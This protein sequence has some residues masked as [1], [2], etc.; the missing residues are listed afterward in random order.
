MGGFARLKRAIDVLRM[1][2]PGPS[3]LVD[4][5]DLVQGSGPA[6]WSRGKVMIAPANALGLDA[7]VP[8]NWEPVY[9]PGRFEELMGALKTRIIAYNFHRKAN[10]ERLFDPAVIILRDGVRIAFVGVADPTTTMRQPPIQ[11]EGL[12]STRMEGFRDYLQDLR[13]QERPD[14]LVAVTHTGLTVSRQLAV[15]NPELDV[16]LSGHTHERTFRAI[17]QGNCLIVEAGSHGSFLGCLDLVLKKGGGIESHS[18]RL[19]PVLDSDFKEDAGVKDIVDGELRPHRERMNRVLCRTEVPILRY[20]VL[21]TNADNL[22]TD[23]VREATGADIGFSNGFRFAPPIAAGALTENDL[24]NLLP[25]DARIKKGWITG[26]QLKTYLEG[27][28]E[29]VFSRNPWKLSG[30]WGPRASGLDFT[31]EA[32]QAPGQRVREIIVNGVPVAKDGRYEIAGCERDGEPMD[33]V[34]RHRGTHDVAIVHPSIQG[35]MQGYFKAH[36]VIAPKVSGRSRATDL[37]ARVFSQD[38]ILT[39]RA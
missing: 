29:L 15:E 16:I 30:G 33:V 39:G 2:A 4:G 21:E 8:G 6:A 7:F 38:R 32:H 14:L 31:F 37:P 11:V 35:V 22:I 17:S 26:A 13:R 23:A 10:N 19:V 28:L 27:E 18:F 9:G 3:F 24:W 25:I 1:R 36:P 5:G 12:D 20:D 34:C